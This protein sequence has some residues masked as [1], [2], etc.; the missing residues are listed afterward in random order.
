[1]GVSTAAAA[2]A[3]AA[4]AVASA[5]IVVWGVFFDGERDDGGEVWL[6]GF[7]WRRAGPRRR[8]RPDAQGDVELWCP[9]GKEEDEF[10]G[11]NLGVRV[12]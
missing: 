8:G 9:D 11:G 3:M 7:L 6:C 10:E 5:A 12:V 2:A 1:M 4:A